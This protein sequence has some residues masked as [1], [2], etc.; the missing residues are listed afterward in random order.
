MYVYNVCAVCTVCVYYACV[1]VHVCIAC[2]YCTYVGA[3]GGRDL[4]VW[5]YHEHF[6][7]G[8]SANHFENVE[9]IQ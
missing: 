1:Y 7:I 5:A 2:A 6:G 3:I 9:V 4:V 8:A